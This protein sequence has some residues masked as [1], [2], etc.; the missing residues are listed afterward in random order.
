MVLEA[1]YVTKKNKNLKSTQ[2]NSFLN[3]RTDGYP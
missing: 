2:K 1:N 3:I